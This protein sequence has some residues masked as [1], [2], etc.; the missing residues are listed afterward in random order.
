MVAVVTRGLQDGSDDAISA[1]L[2]DER[3]RDRELAA[4]VLARM[5]FRDTPNGHHLDPCAKWSRAKSLRKVKGKGSPSCAKH[6]RRGN[7][8]HAIRVSSAREQPLRTG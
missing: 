2:R 8:S 4:E 5:R 1:Q 7:Q 3:R 6:Q